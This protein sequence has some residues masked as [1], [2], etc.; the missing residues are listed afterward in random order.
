ML[1]QVG[2][3]DIAIE[4]FDYNVLQFDELSPDDVETLLAMALDRTL[5]DTILAAGYREP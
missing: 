3:R 5:C 2:C 4:L 1:K